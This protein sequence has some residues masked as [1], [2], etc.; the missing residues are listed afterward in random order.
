MSHSCGR[1][2]CAGLATATP[3]DGGHRDRRADDGVVSAETAVE[4]MHHLDRGSQYAS[5]PFQNKLKIYSMKG[6]MSRKGNCWDNA[7]TES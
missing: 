7:P 4:L 6:S 5:Q 2:K 3:N 1:I